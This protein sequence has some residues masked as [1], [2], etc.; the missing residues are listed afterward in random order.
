MKKILFIVSILLIY[1]TLNAQ[2]VVTQV[3][4][5]VTCCGSPLFNPM[6][7]SFTVSPYT[8]SDIYLFSAGGNVVAEGFYLVN[9]NYYVG[10]GSKIN[11]SSNSYNYLDIPNNMP[12]DTIMYGFKKIGEV[13][14]DNN[15]CDSNAVRYFQLKYTIN[16]ATEYYGW[17]KLRYANYIPF[18]YGLEK[19]TIYIESYGMNTIPNEP[20]L[21]GQ[22]APTSVQ[23]NI[24]I[25]NINVFPNPVSSIHHIQFENQTLNP[26]TIE[27]Y[28]I[29]GK[30]M[31][32]IHTNFKEPNIDIQ[33][34]NADIPDGLYFYKVVVDKKTET[35]LFNKQ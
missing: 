14:A 22:T 12:Y 1:I 4:K 26:F 15:W 31:K 32:T 27:L 34:D 30:K 35:I 16:A 24:K 19:D 3:N 33:L 8:N 29:Q 5:K 10:V 2:I 6:I 25:S 21:M 17:L 28:S 13:F 9:K 23:D 18:S 11:F 20:I 7:D